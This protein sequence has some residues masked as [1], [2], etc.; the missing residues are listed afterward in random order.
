MSFCLSLITSTYAA[1]KSAE[2]STL[3]F[4]SGLLA[5]RIYDLSLPY[6]HATTA[7]YYCGRGANEIRSHSNIYHEVKYSGKIYRISRKQVLGALYAGTGLVDAFMALQE[8]TKKNVS[9]LSN[10]LKHAGN[11]CFFFANLIE[12]EGNI[13]AYRKSLDTDSMQARKSAILG[14]LTNLG[15]ISAVVLAMFNSTM[16]AAIIITLT[17]TLAVGFKIVYDFLYLNKY[18]TA[19]S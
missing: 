10:W 13:S 5:Q 6:I 18:L 9:H 2:D 11:T 14:I 15:Y 3:H 17:T 4:I 1:L 12:L 19:G 16:T 8:F 7:L